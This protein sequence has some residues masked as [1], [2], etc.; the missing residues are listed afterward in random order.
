MNLRIWKGQSKPLFYEGFQNKM[1]QCVFCGYENWRFYFKTIVWELQPKP[2][3]WAWTESVPD[4]HYSPLVPLLWS[5][6]RHNM[7]IYL[8]LRTQSVSMFHSTTC[9]KPLILMFIFT[10]IRLT[11]KLRNTLCLDTP[12]ILNTQAN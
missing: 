11:I 9:S 10:E 12:I 4:V 8:S 6:I 3:W 2:K 7:T 5:N 1:A